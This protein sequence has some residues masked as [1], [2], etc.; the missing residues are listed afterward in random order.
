[1]QNH[2]L[3]TN[4]EKMCADSLSGNTPQSIWPICLN[5]PIIWDIFE[6]IS[7]HVHCLWLLVCIYCSVLDFV[8][9]TKS[10]DYYTA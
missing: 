5:R 7:S 4:N 10:Y 8:V 6:K 1:M 9:Q 2:N 3:G